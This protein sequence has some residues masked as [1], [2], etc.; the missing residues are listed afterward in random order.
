MC[1]RIRAI[2]KAVG[3]VPSPV[4][5][6][7]YLLAIPTFGLIYTR[8]PHAFYHS[9]VRHEPV[10]DTDAQRI[11]IGLR[12]EIIAQFKE[13]HGSATEDV[14][15]WTFNVENIHLGALRPED[16]RLTF[17]LR[18]ELDGRGKMAGARLYTG[19][20]VTIDARI[21]LAVG[22]PGDPNRRIFAEPHVSAEEFPVPPRILFP[23][24][25]GP[26]PTAR[27][28]PVLA[29]TGPLHEKVV[30]F[31]N[32]VRGFPEAASGSFPRMFYFSAVTIT[33]LGY[34]DIVPITNRARITVAVE[35]IL[36]IVFVG[37]FINS[38]FRER[39]TRQTK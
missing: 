39:T 36:G 8:M 5:A 32:A 9:T 10:L 33:T 11:L 2:S 19:T 30:A 16:T 12:E 6:A 37:L 27:L 35:S 31:L 3:T 18:T 4:F 23:G 20:D 24:T 26:A 1:Q 7:L 17:T 29:I 38:L 14:G 21:R 28:T 15:D 22:F 13:E 34:G 25:I